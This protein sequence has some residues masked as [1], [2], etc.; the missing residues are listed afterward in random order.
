MPSGEV[1][2]SPGVVGSG[3]V[4]APA[5]GS[6]GVVVPAFGSVT[7]P[8]F[9]SITPVVGGITISVCT[10]QFLV[11]ATYCKSKGCMVLPYNAVKLNGRTNNTEVVCAEQPLC[12]SI[13]LSLQMETLTWLVQVAVGASASDA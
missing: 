1:V 7:V 4:V 12:A 11:G 8:V 5:F 3:G 2:G 13:P 10:V 9:G 6:V